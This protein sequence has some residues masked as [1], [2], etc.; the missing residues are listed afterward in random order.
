MIRTLLGCCVGAFSLENLRGHVDRNLLSFLRVFSYTR[1][2]Q[3]VTCQTYLQVQKIQDL[4]IALVPVC[5][6]Y[7]FSIEYYFIVLDE[8]VEAIF[9]GLWPPT[10]IG[11][12]LYIEL[13]RRS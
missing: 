1:Y 11:V 4:R 12:L 5:D 9:I 6:H 10:I 7:H 8:P 13:K 2:L 3:M